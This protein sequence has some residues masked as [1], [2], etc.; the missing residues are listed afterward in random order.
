[1]FGYEAFMIK[2]ILKFFKRKKNWGTLKKRI[3]WIAGY[4]VKYWKEM[5]FYTVLGLS[6]TALSLVT[7]L[8]SKDLV[9]IITGHQTGQ[10]ISTFIMMIGMMR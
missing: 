2:K 1:M 4:A 9:D 5:I 6:G 10:V 8:I 7:S 3:L